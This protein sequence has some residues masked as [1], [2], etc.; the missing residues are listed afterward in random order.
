LNISKASAD[1]IAGSPY[2]VLTFAC[3]NSG[4][5][6]YPSGA[7]NPVSVGATMTPA[8]NIVGGSISAGTISTLTV[9]DFCSSPTWSGVA[10]SGTVTDSILTKMAATGLSTN[11]T[12]LTSTL[13][14]SVGITQYATFSTSSYFA[15]NYGVNRASFTSTTPEFTLSSST[16][17]VN[18]A[19]AI[20]GYTIT[21][22]GG[23][24]DSYSITPTVSNGLSFSTTTGLI[25]GIPTAVAPAVTYTITATNTAGSS[26]ATYSLTVNAAPSAPAL[27]SVTSGDR[28]VTVAFT[29]GANNGAA[30]TDYEYSLNGGSYTSAGTTTSPFTVTGLS[31]RTSYSVTIKARNSI[32]L[33][34]ASASLSATTTDASQDASEAT[35]AAAAAKK[36]KE[37]KEL[38]E[39]LSVIPS[40]AGLALNLGD[41][42][43]SLLT[44]KC[45][46]GKTVKNVKKGAKC[47]KGYVKKK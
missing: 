45:V 7:S 12:T 38:T 29:A 41:L 37:Q 27:N 35:A 42:T 47:P 25:S 43:N 31:G 5:I 17:T 24:I 18:T 46:K 21:S 9:T 10:T 39:L 36:A 23:A 19:T 2:L 40:I 8:S 33:S 44:T 22:T 14:V 1:V 11:T 20:V 4:V 34:S 13:G 6:F 16:E 26:T 28:R 32:G 30:I 15:G 3:G